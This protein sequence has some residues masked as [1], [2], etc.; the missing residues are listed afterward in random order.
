MNNI[1]K[2]LLRA[3]DRARACARARNKEG[4]AKSPP[5][6]LLQRDGALKNQPQSKTNPATAGFHSRIFP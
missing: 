2:I 1:C 4:I 5:I 3:R 6:F